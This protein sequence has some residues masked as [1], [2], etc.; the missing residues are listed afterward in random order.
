MVPYLWMRDFVF[1]GGIEEIGD[2]RLARGAKD[3]DARD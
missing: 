2:P 1:A 3:V